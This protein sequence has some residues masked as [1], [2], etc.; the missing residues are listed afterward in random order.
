M[1][2]EN[3]EQIVRELCL[4]MLGNVNSNMKSIS[5]SCN[6]KKEITVKFIL[7]SKSELEDELIDDTICDFEVL[8]NSFLIDVE[9]EIHTK[10][11]LSNLEHVVFAAYIE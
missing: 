1:N 11:I 5:F 9:V 8:R 7:F 4:S 10:K 2:Q 3:I 6:N